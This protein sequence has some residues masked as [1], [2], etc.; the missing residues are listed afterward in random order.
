MQKNTMQKK[1]FEP[2]RATSNHSGGFVASAFRKCS[3]VRRRAA[4][5]IRSLNVKELPLELAR[6]LFSELTGLYDR[7]TLRAYFGTK[8]HKS[9]R[10]IR[11]TSRYATGTYSFKTIELSQQVRTTKGYLEKMGLATFELRG[12]TWF[13]IVHRDAVLVPQLYER[14]QV[15][16]E[17]FSLSPSSPLVCVERRKGDSGNR[18]TRE[19]ET[20]N[21]L[22]GEREKSVYK[23]V[24]E[25]LTP[26]EQTI[27]RVEPH[28]DKASRAKPERGASSRG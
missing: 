25:K 4:N 22:Q 2:L 28:G 26:L 10:K 13:M 16:M 7:S 14:K 1:D 9:V 20:N 6:D 12:K 8:A 17:N 5:F 15:S 3:T 21:N 19:L 24:Y 11:R 18:S 27:L 23:S